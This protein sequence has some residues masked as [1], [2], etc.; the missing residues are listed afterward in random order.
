MAMWWLMILKLGLEQKSLFGCLGFCIKE[1][2]VH[3]YLEATDRLS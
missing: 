1:T 3:Q 2:V